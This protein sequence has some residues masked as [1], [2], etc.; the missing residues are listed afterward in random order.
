[1]CTLLLIE[2]HPLMR[3][4]LASTLKA[5]PAW[6]LAPPVTTAAEA[7]AVVEDAM[8]DLIIMEV[9]LPDGCGLDLARDLV[10]QHP[11]LPVLMLG[12]HAEGL[13]AERALRTGARGY[14]DHHDSGAVITEAVKH[15]L[16]GNYYISR[17]AENDLLHAVA[18]RAEPVIPSP[19]DVLSP[20]EMEYFELTG[21][22]LTAQQTAEKMDVTVATVASYR[23]RTKQ[24]LHVRRTTDLVRLA[25]KWRSEE[26][27]CYS[28]TGCC[29]P[30]DGTPQSAT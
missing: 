14:V 11:D 5:E 17:A 13:C 4:G 19:S 10:E 27:T 2:P 29:P 1:M 22:G 7:R 28:W 24:K 3:Q 9:V 25:F 21:T 15:L 12:Q 8:P 18:H 6:Q 20:R 16:Q 23:A 26:H 30:V